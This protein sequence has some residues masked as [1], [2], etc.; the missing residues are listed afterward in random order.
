MEK[1]SDWITKKMVCDTC[2]EEFEAI[3]P[4]GTTEIECPICEGMNTLG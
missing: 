4:E 3:F 1:M 2:G